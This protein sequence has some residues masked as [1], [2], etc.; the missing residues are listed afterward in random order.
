MALAILDV[1]QL[2]VAM[3]QGGAGILEEVLDLGVVLHTGVDKTGVAGELLG[4]VL[5]QLGLALCLFVLASDVLVLLVQ[6]LDQELDE[7]LI[8]ALGRD[9]DQG[10]DEALLPGHDL[11]HLGKLV[12]HLAH[13]DKLVLHLVRALVIAGARHGWLATNGSWKTCTW[14]P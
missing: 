12:L 8:L 5:E 3:G 1:G 7:L 14:L 4:Q 13:L 9:L 2:L 6:L 11:V 10:L